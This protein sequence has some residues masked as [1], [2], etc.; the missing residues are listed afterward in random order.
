[1]QSG[2]E[3]MLDKGFYMSIGILVITLLAYGGMK[4]FNMKMS[5]DIEI[6]EAQAKEI[7]GSLT[8][9]KLDNAI[10][11]QQRLENI[12]DN[13]KA[14]NEA[15]VILQEVAKSVVPGA[16]IVSY[17]DGSSGISLTMSADNFFTI[18]KQ[19][20]SFKKAATFSD[21]TVSNAQ[22]IDGGVTFELNMNKV[23]NKQVVQK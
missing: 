13:L 23:T 6:A 3:R 18:A 17:E 19:I 16:R 10:D 2:S 14:R 12:S 20:L 5:N 15:N 8:K 21:V 11:F 22:R 1:M 9:D 7:E 4:F